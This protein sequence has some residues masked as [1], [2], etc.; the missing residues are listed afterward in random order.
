MPNTTSIAGVPVLTV[1]GNASQACHIHCPA[2]VRMLL[3]T[4][5]TASLLRGS[6]RGMSENRPSSLNVEMPKFVRVRMNTTWPRCD[7]ACRG[8]CLTRARNRIGTDIASSRTRYSRQASVSVHRQRADS[9][10]PV[11]SG[12]APL[13]RDCPSGIS[14]PRARWP[15]PCRPLNLVGAAANRAAALLQIDSAVLVGG[16]ARA[17]RGWHRAPARRLP[18]LRRRSRTAVRHGHALPATTTVA[19]R[20]NN[21]S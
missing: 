7:A 19:S 8:S 20:A 14:W 6:P 2:M 10:I 5:P 4:E 11:G 21:R 15:A 16:V 9:K 13:F 17:A 3:R 1:D 18:N 12:A